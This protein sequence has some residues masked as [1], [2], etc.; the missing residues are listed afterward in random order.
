MQRR[1]LCRFCVCPCQLGLVKKVENLLSEVYFLWKQT[2]V[3]RDLGVK[4]NKQETPAVAFP[5]KWPEGLPWIALIHLQL[6]SIKKAL[7]I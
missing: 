3:R 4:T 2:F 6:I 5:D 7:D 1:Q